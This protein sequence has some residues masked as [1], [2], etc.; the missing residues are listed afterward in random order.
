MGSAVEKKAQFVGT[1]G[2]CG[3]RSYP[4]RDQA[5]KASNAGQP[6]E[7]MSAYRCGDYWHV[8][9]LPK[10][11]RT[12]EVSRAQIRTRPERLRDALTS[13]LRRFR[14][15]PSDGSAWL[16]SIAAREALHR[17]MANHPAGGQR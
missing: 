13:A 10:A 12:G 9:H 3:K 15:N 16:R 17:S 7:H 8:G 14:G 6:S 1:C 11:V 5:R 2:E 4:T